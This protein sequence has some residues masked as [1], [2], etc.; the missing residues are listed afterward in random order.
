MLNSFQP[1]FFNWHLSN[2][3]L[4]FVGKSRVELTFFIEKI[5]FSMKL[6]S[7]HFMGNPSLRLSEVFK[8]FLMTFN[9]SLGL[10]VHLSLF[11]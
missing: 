4:F 1:I 6:F 9:S 2:E 5:S 8:D 11:E 7:G 10:F 3:K